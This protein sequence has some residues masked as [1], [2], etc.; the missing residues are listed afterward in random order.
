MSVR[1]RQSATWFPP[2]HGDN[3]A[4]AVSAAPSLAIGRMQPSSSRPGK[5]IFPTCFSPNSGGN[6][7]TMFFSSITGG[8]LMKAHKIFRAGAAVALLGALAGA[9]GLQAQGSDSPYSY[10]FK[11]R[12]GLV[13]GDLQASHYD[14]KVMGFGAEVRYGMPGIGGALSAELTYEVVPGRHRD[15]T[16]WEK[17]SEGRLIMNAPLVMEGYWSYDD[18]KEKGQGWSLRMAYNSP[19]PA[20]GPS[21]ISDITKKMEWF[22]GLGIDRY[23]VF[24]EF[25]WTLRDQS[26]DQFKAPYRGG[27]RPPLYTVGDGEFKARAGGGTFD[28]EEASINVG[29]FAGIKYQINSDLAFEVALRNFGMKHWDFTAGAYTGTVDGK[30]ETGSSRGTSIEFALCLKL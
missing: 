5:A 25:Q 26:S 14:N 30:L 7:E 15:I 4:D 1:V 19:M 18:R 3:G 22:G 23:K 27:T 12:G 10:A 6:Q 21:I 8:A 28:K 16:K 9:P 20:F 13:G 2:P 11:I 17:D 29:I 24:S